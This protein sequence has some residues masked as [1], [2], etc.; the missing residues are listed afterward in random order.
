[1][2]ANDDWIAARG[3]LLPIEYPYGNFR[4]NYYKLTTSAV[5]GYLGQPMDMDANGQAFPATASTAGINMLIGPI[6]GFADSNLN[7]L[8]SSMLRVDAAPYLSAQTDA[9]VLIAD[10][11]DQ[12]FVIQVGTGGA[13]AT[14]ANQ[15]V[16]I[17]TANIGM[18]GTFYYRS[19]SGNTTTGYCTAELDPQTLSTT[20]SGC[21]QI[22]GVY[23]LKN[24]DGSTNAVGATSSAVAGEYTKV[25]VRCTAHRFSMTQQSLSAGAV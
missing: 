20:G 23:P 14:G 4:K 12:C 6:V 13:G 18:I 16:C 15:A 24:S 22:I 21:F 9:Y 11:P 2:S 8:P 25:R 1:M 10:D 3:G 7:A 5:A 17:T 19:S